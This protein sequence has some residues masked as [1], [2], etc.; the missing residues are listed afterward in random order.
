MGTLQETVVVVG[1][2]ENNTGARHSR[3]V[4]MVSIL[5]TLV[6]P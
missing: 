1:K 4:V 6:I 5:Y 2:M 3:T